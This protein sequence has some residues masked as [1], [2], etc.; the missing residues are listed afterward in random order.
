[1]SNDVIDGQDPL[2]HE[3]AA[4]AADSAA[5]ECLLRCWARE[6]NAAQPLGGVW[7]ITLNATG[8]SMRVPVAW[9]RTA[10]RAF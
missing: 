2:E 1:M 10:A 8:V 5:I 4:H 6:T 9:G 7:E 3:S